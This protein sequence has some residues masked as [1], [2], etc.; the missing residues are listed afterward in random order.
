MKSLDRPISLL[1]ILLAVYWCF[2]AEMPSD[3]S[4]KNL[5]E[6]EFSTD[7]ALK[8]VEQISKEPHA[9]GFPA[10][11]KVRNYIVGELQKLGLETRV[12]EGYTTGD[13]ANYSKAVNILARIEGEEDGKALVLMSHYDSSPHSS[14]GASDAG[15]GVATVLEGMRA[16]LAEGQTPKNDII[17]LITDSEELGLNGADLFVNQHPWAR[18]TGLVLNF[19]AR[20]SGGPE[21]YASGN[22]SG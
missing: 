4:G 20:G 11:T 15:S 1:L 21:L 2:K 16:F 6:T 19:E 22:Q 3:S 17:I 5:T 13:W 8:H 7:L 10:H 12:Q 9:V 14:L 18:E